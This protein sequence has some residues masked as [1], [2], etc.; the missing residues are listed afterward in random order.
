MWHIIVSL[1][2]WLNQDF[3]LFTCLTITVVTVT[4]LEVQEH[5]VMDILE[6]EEQTHQAQMTC[7]VFYSLE[8]L[9]V[10]P[11]FKTHQCQ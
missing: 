5:F 9:N 3:E 11:L 6:V 8:E 1:S 2:G 7:V 10:N 4:G